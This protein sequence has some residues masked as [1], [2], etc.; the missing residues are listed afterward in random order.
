MS[1]AS[2]HHLLRDALCPAVFSVV[3]SQVVYLCKPSNTVSG[4]PVTSSSSNMASHGKEEE[5]EGSVSSVLSF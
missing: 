2:T 1:T 5:E 4:L 3:P